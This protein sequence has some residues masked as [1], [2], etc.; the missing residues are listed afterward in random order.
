MHNGVFMTFKRLVVIT[1][2]SCMYTG[3]AFATNV[4]LNP[5]G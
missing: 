5:A 2:I 4:S 3:F 1:A